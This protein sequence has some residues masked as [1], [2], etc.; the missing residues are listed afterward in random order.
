VRLADAAQIALRL[1]AAEARGLVQHGARTIRWGAL[2][3]C[4]WRD[5]APQEVPNPP[6]MLH[7]QERQFLYWY[8]KAIYDGRGA[9]VDL[10]AFLGAS[11]A[12]MAA[13]LARNPAARPGIVHSFDFFTYADFHAALVPDCGLAPGDDTVPLF[14]RHVG[15]HRQF[16]RVVKGDITRAQWNAPIA[17][18]F[19]DFTQSWD[20][21]Q[22]VIETFY[23]H[24]QVGSYL[25]HQDYIY[26]LCYWLHIWMERWSACFQTVAAH[27]PASTAAWKLVKPLPPEA[28]LPLN[29]QLAA[30]ELLALLDRSIARYATASDVVRMMLGC[31]RAR[32]FVHVYGPDAAADIAA[33]LPAH[34][35]VLQLRDEIA[36]W[37][38]GPS[39]YAG[40]FRMN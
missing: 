6:S 18:L 33:S 5:V 11:A 38:Q 40:F 28:F 15:P 29:A 14:W 27:V 10:G 23:P 31:A 39:P 37:R 19:V 17:F 32:F 3:G 4:P 36:R 20:H 12:C 2:Q 24:L 34:P 1:I 21:H 7:L 16:V 9:L 30:P 8:A 26:V 22:R 13:G 25:A 35:L